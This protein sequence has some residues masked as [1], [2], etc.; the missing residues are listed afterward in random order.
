MRFYLTMLV[1]LLVVGTCVLDAR[2][3]TVEHQKFTS[4]LGEERSS[5]SFDWYVER[6]WEMFKARLRSSVQTGLVPVG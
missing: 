2:P 1:V 3:V 4:Q 5:F 6:V